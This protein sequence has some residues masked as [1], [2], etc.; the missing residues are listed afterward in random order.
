MKKKIPEIVSIQIYINKN[1][2]STKNISIFR[3]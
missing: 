1:P 3:E 2:N